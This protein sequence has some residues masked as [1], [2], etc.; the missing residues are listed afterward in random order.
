MFAH[1]WHCEFKLPVQV[2]QDLSQLSQ[3]WVVVFPKY[4]T[5][6]NDGQVLDDGIK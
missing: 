2:K 5:G 6:H 3:L 4:P 1:D